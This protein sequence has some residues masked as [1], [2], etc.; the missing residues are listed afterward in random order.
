M[1]HQ[2]R[3][4]F[5]VLASHCFVLVA[6]KKFYGLKKDPHGPYEYVLSALPHED[7]KVLTGLPKQWDWRDVGGEDYTSEVQNQH[8]PGPTYCGACW[9]FATTTHLNARF[10][11]MNGGKWPRTRLSVQV[12]ITCGPA[13]QAGCQG[14]DPGLALKFIH[15]IGLPH[16]SCHEYEAKDLT[17]NSQAV[18]QDCMIDF[19]PS[20]CW[21]RKHFP[22]YRVKEYGSIR[23]NG[24]ISATDPRERQPVIDSM[25]Q[26]MKAEI[27]KRG[28]IVCQLACP[29][30]KSGEAHSPWPNKATG[31]VGYG[32]VRGY[33]DDYTPFF[34]DEGENFAPFILNNTDYV[35]PGGDWDTCVD[36]DLTV[37]GWGDEKG[38]PYWIIQNSW[39]AWWGEHGFFRVVMGRNNLG[40][41]SGCFWGVPAINEGATGGFHGSSMGSSEL[42]G[43]RFKMAEQ[44]ASK[45]KET[46]LYS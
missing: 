5:A 44:M 8:Q 39:G 14:S 21:A 33:V 45:Q 37:V 6:A 10:N 15:E 1:V 26:R 35:C 9:A 28:P 24:N 18:C 7:A 11:I 30:P 4:L 17:C 40:I 42:F 12:L 19:L 20:E 3:A 32:N 22:I 43:E 29:D 16:E 31:N 23:P 25:V 13:L 27:W 34:N 41:E 38:M 2:H 46:V 36:H